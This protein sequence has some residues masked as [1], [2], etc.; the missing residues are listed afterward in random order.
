MP[1]PPSSRS[2]SIDLAT[3]RALEARRSEAETRLKKA[4]RDFAK[5]TQK[6]KEREEQ[7]AKATSDVDEINAEMAAFV[8]SNTAVLMSDERAFQLLLAV[9]KEE[10]ETES[11][12]EGSGNPALPL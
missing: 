9:G 10:L 1:K 6:L 7:L 2:K 5:A 12:V 3:G 4:R 11:E 8:K